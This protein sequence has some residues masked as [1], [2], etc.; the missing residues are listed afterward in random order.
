[1]SVAQ[2]LA[3]EGCQV[4]CI[5]SNPE[6]IAAAKG[7][8]THCVQL[9]ATDEESLRAVGI[10]GVDVAIV[11]LGQNMEAAVM[12]TL[13]LKEL[14]VKEIIAKAVT[15]LHGR[16]LQKIG[17]DR[18]VFPER[19]MGRRV[20][21]SLVS[22]NIVEH[23]ELSAGCSLVELAAPDFFAGKTIRELA[24][25][26]RYGVTIVAIRKKGSGGERTIM[27]PGP[28]ETI[29]KEDILVVIGRDS[30]L[31]KLQGR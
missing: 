17:A 28:E 23:L 26:S 25:R 15:P 29:E 18:L 14:G 7:F 31:K 4:L 13:L 19:D 6:K 5:D 12:T 3:E 8:A 21:E 30:D 10:R 9:D 20:A 1:M 11:S 2:T 24:I 27:N 22:P 16:I